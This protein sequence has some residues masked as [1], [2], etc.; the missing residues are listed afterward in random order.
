MLE[1]I[2]T[3]IDR[4]EPSRFEELAL[5]VFA[6]QFERVPAYRSLCE[7]RGL[8]PD[9]VRRFE[10]APRVSTRS[11][12]TASLHAADPVVVFRSSGTSTGTR[13]QHHHP[14]PQLYRRVVDATFPSACMPTPEAPILSLIPSLELAPDSSLSFMADHVIARFGDATSAWAVGRRG[15]EAATAR[16]WLASRQRQHRPVVILAT[17]LSLDACLQGL[18]RLGLKF[19]LPSGSR[20]FETGGAKAL[21]TSVDVESM[22]RRLAESLAA[23]ATAI[24]GEYGMTELTSQAYT[25]PGGVV[26]EWPPWVRQRVL[27]PQTLDEVGDGEIGVLSIFDLANLGSAAHVLT[28]DLVRRRGDGFEFVGRPRDAELRGCS[29]TAEEFERASGQP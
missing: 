26:Y 28:E 10:D 21:E 1:S 23:P 5:R 25:A 7:S 8:S 19:R 9:N 14:Y 13:S 6:F 22:H 15:I 12:K 20:I 2:E 18:E 17:S 16:S 24:V 29:L 11:F 27:D 3:F 4:P